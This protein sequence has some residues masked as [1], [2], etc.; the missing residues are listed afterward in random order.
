MTHRSSRTK[1]WARWLATFIGFPASR[2]RPPV[3]V[4]GD[5]DDVGGRRHRRPD[6][7]RSC[8]APS[9]SLVGGI[10]RE[11]SSSV[12]R[13]RLR[14]GS[15]PV[16]L[17]GRA[18]SDIEPTVASLAVMGAVCGLGVGLAQAVQCPDA[19]RSI[20]GCGSRPRR[21]SGRSAG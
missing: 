6:G 9:R 11:R 5:V 3:L 8:S 17:S 18:P 14:A 19:R 2:V 21:C 7:R 20:G 16:S 1:T 4:V 15:Q 12:D 10:P 13:W